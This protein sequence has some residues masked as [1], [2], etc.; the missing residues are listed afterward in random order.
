MRGAVLVLVV[1]LAA[2][3][4][5][6]SGQK[7]VAGKPAGPEPTCEGACRHYLGCKGLH[8]ATSWTICTTR[9]EEEQIH[10]DYLAQ[11]Q[12]LEC[13]TA[14]RVVDERVRAAREQR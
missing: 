1:L 4:S 10:P 7:P 6:S 13:S 12:T 5:S 8:D 14:V 3:S 9:C 2:A 11:Y